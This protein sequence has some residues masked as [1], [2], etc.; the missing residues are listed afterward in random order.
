MHPNDS[1]LSAAVTAYS[2]ARG[3]LGSQRGGSGEQC[4]WER[5]ERKRWSAAQYTGAAHPQH[6]PG[7]GAPREAQAMCSVHGGKAKSV[8]QW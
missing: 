3:R 1:P 5:G 6:S 4:R 2:G 8:P 7:A